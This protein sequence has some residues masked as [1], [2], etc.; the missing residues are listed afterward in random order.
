MAES[1]QLRAVS[2][3]PLIL[4]AGGKLGQTMGGVVYTDGK[5]LPPP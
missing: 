5:M 2:C 3:K 4:Q 1:S